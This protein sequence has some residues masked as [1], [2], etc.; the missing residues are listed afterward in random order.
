VPFFDDGHEDIDGYGYPYL[1]L[2]R[3]LGGAEKRLDAQVLFD[4]L[5]EKLD[6]P[7]IKPP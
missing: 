6:L 4:P 5:E 3:V 1:G 2:D 7:A